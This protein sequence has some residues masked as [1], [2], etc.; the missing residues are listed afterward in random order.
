MRSH[1][2]VS[3]SESLSSHV[4]ASAKD[5]LER[6]DKNYRKAIAQFQEEELDECQRFINRGELHI[7]LAEH[8]VRCE[9]VPA[10][11]LDFGSSRI[12]SQLLELSRSIVKIKL[13]VEYANC[14]V[15]PKVQKG[16]LTASKFSEALSFSRLEN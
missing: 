7:H 12:E 14:A 15:P 4:P 13:T 16:S 3:C 1:A 8:Q 10:L 9:E 11:E 5:H 6:A 2:S